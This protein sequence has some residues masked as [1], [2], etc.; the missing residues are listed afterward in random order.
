MTSLR[1]TLHQHRLTVERIA[2]Q[3]RRPKVKVDSSTAGAARRPLFISRAARP[4]LSNHRPKVERPSSAETACSTTGPPR[5]ASLALAAETPPQ[6]EM[7][8]AGTLNEFVR[9]LRWLRKSGVRA[10]AKAFPRK[11]DREISRPRG[12][13]GA[14]ATQVGASAQPGPRQLPRRS[15]SSF[16]AIP[17]L[18]ALRNRPRILEAV[19]TTAKIF[20]GKQSNCDRET[21]V[22]AARTPNA[23]SCGP[24][25]RTPCRSAA[26]TRP[27]EAR[28]GD[29][30]LQRHVI[31]PPGECAE[32]SG[33][34]SPRQSSTVLFDE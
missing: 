25:C 17:T 1:G 10:P 11:R 23:P 16:G 30:P 7:I 21:M 2:V 8:F 27:S 28:E 32:R 24:V 22:F 29:R 31:P 15:R 19:T 20:G 34:E 13:V 18:G 12:A 14:K 26:S 3:R 4:R 9:S 5:Q 33:N 6:T